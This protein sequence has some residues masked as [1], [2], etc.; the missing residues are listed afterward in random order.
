MTR[1]RPLLWTVA[2]LVALTACRAPDPP[3]PAPT[4]EAAAPPPTTSAGPTDRH[5]PGPV[6]ERATGR[7]EPIERRPVALEVDAYE[8][9]GGAVFLR[10][11]VPADP[12]LL[13]AGPLEDTRLTVRGPRHGV[14]VPAFEGY[15]PD[16]P[17]LYV[18]LAGAEPPPP[19]LTIEWR[20]PALLEGE[21]GR[22]QTLTLTGIAEA[23]PFDR[24]APRVYEA[25]AR[26]LAGRGTPGE[27]DGFRAFSAGRMLDAA[28]IGDLRRSRRAS[29]LELMALYAADHPTEEL[30]LLDRG[31]RLPP[32]PEGAALPLDAVGALPPTGHPWDDIRGAAEPVIEPLAAFAPAEWLYLHLAD[33]GAGL[34]LLDDLAR[35]A[36][37]V[38]AALED[39]AGP[40]RLVERYLGQLGLDRAAMAKLDPAVID[41]AVVASDPF[42][43]DGADLTL[44]LRASDPA[45][46]E[47]ILDA[48]EATRR[49]AVSGATIGAA[50]VAGRAVRRVESPDRALSLHRVRVDDV[51]LLSN[52]GAALARVLAARDGARPL[53]GSGVL[54][55]FRAR[56]PRAAKGAEGEEVAFLLVGDGAL[57]H[58]A[59]PRLRLT[60]ARRM[61]AL[62]ALRAVGHAALLHGWLEGRPV[63][64]ATADGR[65][66]LAESG[67]LT[68]ADLR[69]DDGEPITAIGATACSD[70]WGC[71][72]AGR[73]LIEVPLDTIG[74]HEAGAYGR[75]REGWLREVR[76]RI[77]PL[78]VQV[79]R[80]GETLAIEARMM[81]LTREHGF[82]AVAELLDGVR[83]APGKSRA[84]VELR[85]P[86]APGSALRADAEARLRALT[87]QRDVGLEWMGPWALAGLADRSG[88]WDAALSLAELPT[89]QGRRGWRDPV[90]RK[91][92]LDRLPLYLVAPVVDRAALDR[93]LAAVRAFVGAEVLDW[94][95]GAPY[96]GVETVEVRER[97]SGVAETRIGLWYA[98][99]GDRLVVGVERA[100]F[101]ALLDAALDGA[102]PAVSAEGGLLGAALT[103]RPAA[104]DGWLVRTLAAVLEAAS[105]GRIEAARRALDALAAGRGLPASTDPAVIERALLDRLGL[106]PEGPHGR[107]PTVGEDGRITHPLYG[108]AL[109]PEWP[110]LP[111]PDSPLSA[112]VEALAELAVRVHFEGAAIDRAL[113]LHLRWARRSGQ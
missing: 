31:E 97:L 96:R 24:L 40:S 49:A 16:R 9:V 14:A 99:A 73:P 94:G 54:R 15:L 1:P 50:T 63:D 19:E 17:L 91:Q 112:L 95:P 66:A 18:R 69:H 107:R 93:A 52:S 8:I 92:V 38:V 64:P 79:R 89:T 39:A 37:P 102:L 41:A 33:P 32:D 90:R 6:L 82:R 109:A 88:L 100:T 61:R 68:E 4:P 86:L 77:A 67:L 59:S 80:A 60:Q 45:A 111:V 11:R 98:V 57:D 26:H 27:G 28:R 87:G 84:G 35:L 85:V 5:D 108:T 23:R 25:L 34:A 7:V 62:A 105:I 104:R 48:A 78:A 13:V 76:P 47:A 20:Q 103:V 106:V 71:A 53:A 75:F 44:L 43:R 81:P 46:V 72:R 110:A 58:L 55:A 29:T 113:V 2:G 21:P 65:A 42:F 74:A 70:R 12:S 10:A 36:G 51:V 30:A 3:A 101:E 83:L 22:S 56:M